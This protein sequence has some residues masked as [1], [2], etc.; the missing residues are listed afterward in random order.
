MIEK[1]L[2]GRSFSVGKDRS[3]HIKVFEEALSS[4]RK[5]SDN[6]KVF[7]TGITG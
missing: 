6:E 4:N 7:I 2:R 1:N 5:D 3:K